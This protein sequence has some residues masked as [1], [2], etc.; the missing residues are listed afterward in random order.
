MAMP[1]DSSPELTPGRHAL[2]KEDGTEARG[3]FWRPWIPTLIPAMTFVLGLGLLELSLLHVPYKEMAWMVIARQYGPAS[4]HTLLAISGLALLVSSLT[5][6][7]CSG[8]RVRILAFAWFSISLLYEYGYQQTLNRYSTGDDIVVALFVTNAEHKLDA[9]ATYLRPLPVA[10]ILGLIFALWSPRGLRPVGWRHWALLLVATV[11]WCLAS[12]RSGLNFP[13]LSVPNTIRS[14][15]SFLLNELTSYRGPREAVTATPARTPVRNLVFVVDEAVDGGHLS[16]NG[17]GR[18]TTPFL[19]E[20]V[21][22]KR[23]LTWG[24]AVSGSTCS[25]A[26]GVLMYTGLQMGDL[27]DRSGASKRVPNIF[28]WA[29]AAGYRTYF[30]DG[31][32]TSYW[33]GP[34]GDL[35][36][37]D[38]WHPASEFA[39][40]R[41]DV[42]MTD[43]KIAKRAQE[44]LSAGDRRFVFIW[45]AGLHYPYYRRFPPDSAPWKPYWQ[46]RTISIDHID[47]LVNAYDNGI[48][49]TTD[50]FFR[51]LIGQNG[52]LPRGSA[53]LY[54]SDHGQSLGRA[55]HAATHCGTGSSE[56]VV[57]LMLLGTEARADETF[58]A[59]HANVFATLLDLM[60]FDPPGRYGLSLL[61]A[62]SSDSGQRFFFGPDLTNGVPIPFKPAPTADPSKN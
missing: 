47:A 53:L 6:A 37:V 5:L 31:Q 40:A 51:T 36:Y 32:M 21:S 8:G 48:L 18:A 26:S 42:H 13:V 4:E 15:S 27:P 59:S 61:R 16:A 52:E 57:P 29:K 20:L 30:L 58:Q 38:E 12:W 56:V 17:Y 49:W 46:Q 2:P 22:S 3:T 35:A 50:G 45:K 7:R 23:M 43:I 1:A 10:A 19:A 25:H 39:S 55:G 60:G 9:I 28:Q 24:Q 44:I 62:S 41:D 14:I 54:T 11:C 33:I 34:A